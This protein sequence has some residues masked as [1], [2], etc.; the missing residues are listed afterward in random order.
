MVYADRQQYNKSCFHGNNGIAY[1]VFHIG[2]YGKGEEKMRKTAIVLLAFLIAFHT[3]NS[4]DIYK[5]DIR[6]RLVIQG[7]GIDADADGKY[8]VTIQSI[9]TNSQSATSSD[10]ASQPPIKHMN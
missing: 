6:N 10:G 5:K 4:N 3:F 2:L 9:D 8:T 1:T 7:I